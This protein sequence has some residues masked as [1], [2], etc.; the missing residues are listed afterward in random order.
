MTPDP[1][2]PRASKKTMFD[3][4]N[5][6]TNGTFVVI[7]IAPRLKGISNTNGSVKDKP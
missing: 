2:D 5:P 6:A 7:D 3:I 4:L 1:N